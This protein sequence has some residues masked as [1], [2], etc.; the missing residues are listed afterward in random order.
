[1][2]IRQLEENDYEMFKRLFDEACFEYLEF[3]KHENPRKYEEEQREKRKVTRARFDF[4]LKTGSSFV[5]ENKGK[6]VSYVASQ[7]IHFMHDVDR[8]LWIEYIVVEQRFGRRGIGLALLKKLINHAESIGIDYIY[9]QVLIL[10]TNRQSDFIL[11]LAS[12][13]LTGNMPF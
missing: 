3:L 5:A 11:R 10:T 6:A 13:L 12:R 4:Y 7:T 2:I 8:L 9:P 1:M